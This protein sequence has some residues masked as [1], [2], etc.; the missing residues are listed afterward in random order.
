MI[1]SK[2]EHEFFTELQ[3]LLTKY[4]ASLETCDNSELIFCEFLK[5]CSIDSTVA[6]F[7]MGTGLYI[8]KNNNAREITEVEVSDE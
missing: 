2:K 1:L 7:T 6:F 4:E 5:N 3:G 8:N